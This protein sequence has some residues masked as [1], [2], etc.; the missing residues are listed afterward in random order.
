MSKHLADMKECICIWE[1]CIA[2]L[3]QAQANTS[4]IEVVTQLESDI[5]LL[6]LSI[7][8]MEC[9]HAQMSARAAYAWHGLSGE[10]FAK[11]MT[12]CVEIMLELKDFMLSLPYPL[13]GAD[14]SDRL[15]N[16][17]C[18][19]QISMYES[20]KKEALSNT[21]AHQGLHVVR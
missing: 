5:Q 9:N 11:E 13:L 20:L 3:Q 21:E 17:L 4:D 6:R 15:I 7:M 10:D 2:L 16:H 12:R 18:Y 19:D 8:Q 1:E 14:Q